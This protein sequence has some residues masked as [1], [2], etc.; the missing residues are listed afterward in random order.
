LRF[1][2]PQ[3]LWLLLLLPALVV[4]Y[5][6]VLK[7]RARVVP[8]FSSLSLLRDALDTRKRW[9]RHAPPALMALA[10]VPLVLAMA[11]PS[12][13]LTLPS[14]NIVLVLAMDVSLSMRASDMKPNRI[15]A[16]KEAAK[17]FIKDLPKSIK[18]GI[19]AFAGTATV[20]QT[21]TDNHDDLVAAID[22]FQL[23][24][25]TA[26]GSALLTALNLLL[27]GSGVDLESN[28]FRDKANE[29]KALPSAQTAQPPAP[30]AVGS[31]NNGAIILL[32][33]GRRTTGADPAKAA[34][35]AADRGVKVYTIGFGTKDGAAL[36]PGM[37][38]NW[39]YYLKLDETALKQMAVMTK[40]EYSH[41][42]SSADLRKIYEGFN[43]RFS[44]ERRET[45]ISFVFVASALLLALLAGYLS[46]RWMR[47]P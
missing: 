20:V 38:E 29:S 46:F 45:E 42:G 24:R 33:D 28:L 4:A 23:Q 22:A 25:G 47:G 3:F 30:V 36:A 43:S 17:A 9:R 1:A 2:W 41:A 35:Q 16:A 5:L 27:P 44:M 34:Q 21:P 15:I 6:V 39:S 32:S 13:S 19:V 11:R 26:T 18:V 8:A 12:S 14:D 31:Y 37:D 10:M 40:G 7:K